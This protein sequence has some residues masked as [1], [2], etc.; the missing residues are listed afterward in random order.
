MAPS[1]LRE[2]RGRARAEQ[3]GRHRL[4]GL[5]KAHYGIH[6]TPDPAKIGHEITNGCVNMTNWDARKLTTLVAPGTI[7]E[8]RD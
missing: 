8:V 3:S 7:V 5:S 6:G 4:L 1:P 2:N